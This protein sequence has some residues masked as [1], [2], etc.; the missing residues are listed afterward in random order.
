M[1]IFRFFANLG[2]HTNITK[3]VIK[4]ES[5]KNVL[6][7][8]SIHLL[9]INYYV[10]EMQ[11]NSMFLITKTL[12]TKLKLCILNAL[13]FTI[14][15]PIVK[16]PSQDF[17]FTL[18]ETLSYSIL[19]V[20]KSFNYF[21]NYPI[22]IITLLIKTELF[23]RTI[24]FFIISLTC[25]LSNLSSLVHENNLLTICYTISPVKFL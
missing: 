18:L 8:L 10:L 24:P 7:P 22:L 20:N 9:N 1:S 5:Y 23:Q 19:H 16:H 2:Y 6:F 25:Q 13:K 15:F 14:P 11:P 17:L 21:L 3:K 12:N 4:F